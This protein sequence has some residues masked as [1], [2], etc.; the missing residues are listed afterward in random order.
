MIVLII[1]EHAHN[2]SSRLQ[3][4]KRVG[5]F[6]NKVFGALDFGGARIAE[7]TALVGK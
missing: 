4:L 2:A 7:L 5:E 3:T 1:T 6:K